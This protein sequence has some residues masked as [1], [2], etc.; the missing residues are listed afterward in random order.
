[1]PMKESAADST[2][3]QVHHLVASVASLQ[4]EL[5]DSRA[6]RKATDAKLDAILAALSKQS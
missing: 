5:D 6:A 4:H 2:L 1:M 3:E